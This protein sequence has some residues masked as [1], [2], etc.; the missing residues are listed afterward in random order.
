[1]RIDFLTIFPGMFA[2][3]LEQ[4]L[5]RQASDKGILEFGVHDLRD[6]THDRHKTVDD[7]SYGGGP[8]MVF[9]PEPIFEAID[10]IRRPGACVVLPDPQG[11]QFDRRIAT[12]LARSTQ[13]IFICGRYEGV[14]ERVREAL[15][16]RSISVGDY[17]TMGGELPS[18]LIVEAVARFVPGVVGRGE[19]VASDSFENSLLD[20]PHYTRPEEYRGLKVPEVLLSGHHEQIRQWRRRMALSRTLERRGD[21]L[22]KASLSSEDREVLEELLH[23]EQ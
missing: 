8:G 11:E 16:D 20:F 4:G 1:M 3:L 13:L 2:P 23:Q 9:K 19:S 15:V 18:M 22:Q 6:F 14:D 17:V 12:D 10:A 5:L 7:V 21:L